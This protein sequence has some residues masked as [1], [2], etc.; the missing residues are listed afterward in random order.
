MFSVMVHELFGAL[1]LPT[2][3]DLKYLSIL[4]YCIRVV[5]CCVWCFSFFFFF[6]K[7]LCYF[8]VED[9]DMVS[10]CLSPGYT[11]QVS[12]YIFIYIYIYHKLV[13]RT[14]E[15]C[16][17]CLGDAFLF[18]TEMVPWVTSSLSRRRNSELHGK[19]RLCL[20]ACQ[21][22]LW[23]LSRLCTKSVL[24][25]QGTYTLSIVCHP[26][27]SPLLNVQGM[28]FISCLSRVSL[29]VTDAVTF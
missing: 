19:Q 18:G 24:H 22:L 6:F 9:A 10:V 15:P 26:L 29:L 17:L 27:P 20:N 5:C 13:T 4:N 1:T 14:C 25:I 12:V 28:L 11:W 3:R 16:F 23:A 21:L 2:L 8:D 7:W